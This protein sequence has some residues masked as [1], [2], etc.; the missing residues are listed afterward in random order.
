MFQVLHILFSFA[1]A[2]HLTPKAFEQMLHSCLGESG[3]KETDNP[4]ES[5]AGRYLNV[6]KSTFHLIDDQTEVK[7]IKA[8][9]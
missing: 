7:E 8:I 4:T 2:G 3:A 5:R 1:R 6:T 9:F